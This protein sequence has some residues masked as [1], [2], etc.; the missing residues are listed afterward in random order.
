[1]YRCKGVFWFNPTFTIEKIPVGIY[2]LYLRHGNNNPYAECKFFRH[3]G[4]GNEDQFGTSDP[5]SDYIPFENHQGRL[6]NTYAGTIDL[7]EKYD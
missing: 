3:F 1:M 5:F 2:H 7:S 4:I 6:M